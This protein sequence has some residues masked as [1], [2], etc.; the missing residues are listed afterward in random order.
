MCGGG[1]GGGMLR[2]RGIGMELRLVAKTNANS[3]F[4]IFFQFISYKINIFALFAG[5][6]KHKN[7]LTN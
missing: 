2:N 7:G 6:N 1:W 4:E 5:F 3:S